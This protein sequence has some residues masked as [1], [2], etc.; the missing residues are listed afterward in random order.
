MACGGVG[1]GLGASFPGLKEELRNR[2]IF[3]SE[4]W[5]G[6]QQGKLIELLKVC[7]EEV[8]FYKENWTEAQKQSA[9]AGDLAGLPVLEKSA[10]RGSE[11]AFCRRG[12]NGFFKQTFHTSGTTGTPI[13]TTFTL[14]ELRE[15][16]AVREVRSAN[17]A[18][19][20]FSQPRATFSGRIVEPDPEETERVY[21]YNAAEKQVYFSAFH[22]K[23]TTA[24]S[25][26]EA[27][28][29][30]KVE[31]MTGYAVSFFL[32]ARYILEQQLA[33]PKLR[34][35][36]TTSEKLTEQMRFVME[37][38]YGCK[39]YEEY[40]TVESALFARSV[41]AVGCTSARMSALL[42]FSAPTERVVSQGRWVRWSP[43]V[44]S[45]PISRSF[46]LDWEIWRVGTPTPA[47]AGGRC[48]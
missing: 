21:R 27:L 28:F 30:H 33:V 4:Q 16:L 32:L 15:S 26:V 35:V 14:S 44:F 43:L 18:G 6:F 19:V 41:N 3:R 12:Q 40:S 34:A 36:I 1:C 8:P 17:W 46:V 9:L 11:P 22:L 39:V 2:E 13:S 23:P 5:Q 24:R 45:A 7:V 47:L 25:Y 20:S 48:R 31:W 29:R 37:K 38:A 42:K 10:L